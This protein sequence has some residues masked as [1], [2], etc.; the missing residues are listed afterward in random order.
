K[1][2]DTDFP[3]TAAAPSSLTERFSQKF[4]AQYISTR[5]T[6]PPTEEE[7]L[8][9]IKDAVADLQASRDASPE[10]SGR[11]VTV[12]GSGRDALV[13]YAAAVEAAMIGNAYAADK[14]DLDYFALAI[15]NNDADSLAKLEKVS[16]G[17]RRV[18]RALIKVRAPEEAAAA[19]LAF[20]N[21]LFNMGLATGDLAAVEGD[22]IRALLGIGGYQQYEGD[23]ARAYQALNAVFVAEGVTVTGQGSAFVEAAAGANRILTQPAP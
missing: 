9:F 15:Q 11:D 21:A 3:G 12:S 18:A 22:P 4:L 1:K 20:V 23:L 19:H 10:F 17:Y 13:S 6:A 16:E 5:G 2:S 14:P 7:M 8:N